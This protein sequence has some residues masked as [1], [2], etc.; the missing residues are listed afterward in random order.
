MQRA[1]EVVP[2]IQPSSVV[3]R[4]WCDGGTILREN[5]LRV[6]HKNIRL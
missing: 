5:N 4:V 1:A 3:A 6:T 2:Q